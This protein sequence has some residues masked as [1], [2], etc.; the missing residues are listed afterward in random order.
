MP[1][2]ATWLRAFALL[3][4]MG[5]VALLAQPPAKLDKE[6]LTKYVIYLERWPADAQIT[7]S[8][9]KNASDLPGFQEVTVERTRLGRIVAQRR[10]FLSKDGQRFF[11]GDVFQLSE[12]PYESTRQLL[13]KGT[14]PSFGPAGAPVTLIEFG[15]LQCPDCAAESKIIRELLPTEFSKQVQVQFRDYPLVQH[16][17]AM[18]AAIAGRCV[19]QSDPALFWDYSDWIYAHQK[20]ITE[21]NFEEKLGQWSK[22]K[23]PG[24]AFETCVA[25]RSTEA[26]VKK[27]IADGLALEVPGTPTLFLNGRM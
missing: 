19:F 23:K 8:D 24:A 27:S 7:L 11:K 16:H 14:W 2:S 6:A 4:V 5:S 25:H 9:P 3:A 18:N 12:P 22:D 21:S 10:Y 17:W 20:E 26:D 13:S 15:D 1:R